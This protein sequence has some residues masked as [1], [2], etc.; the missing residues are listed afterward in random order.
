MMDEEV[1]WLK[2][3]AGSSGEATEADECGSGSGGRT[4][5]LHP[6]SSI[7]PAA[8]P[9]SYGERLDTRTAAPP[10]GNSDGLGTG[11]LRA[12]ERN[13]MDFGLREQRPPSPSR[14]DHYRLSHMA[15]VALGAD[16]GEQHQISQN[17]KSRGDNTPRD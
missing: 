3:E 17:V 4:P 14:A 13:I 1:S 9:V 2:R 5:E 8:Q 7:A 11:D 10:D 16:S 6:V 12:N 15:N